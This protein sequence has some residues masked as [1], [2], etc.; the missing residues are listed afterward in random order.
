MIVIDC[1]FF[2]TNIFDDEDNSLVSEVFSS[3]ERGELEAI[4]PGIFFYEIHNSL[5]TAVRRKRM[6]KT[7]VPEYL[8]LFALAPVKIV[9]GGLPDT[10]MNIAFS[11]GLSF[12]DASYLELAERRNIPLATLDSK[13][14]NAAI[15]KGIAYT[16]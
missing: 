2:L 3:I 7:Q 16:V 5:I 10:I 13:L 1:S 9:D 8:K 15:E 6:T 12:Y 4:A 11:F 14:H